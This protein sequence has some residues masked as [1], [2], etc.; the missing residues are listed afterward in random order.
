MSDSDSFI[1]EV[2]EEVRQDR[3]LRYWKR[4]GPWVIGAI[5]LVSPPRPP[6]TGSS[7]VRPSRRA[8]GAGSS[9]PPSPATWPPPPRSSSASTARPGSSRL[10]HAGALAR[11]GQTEAAIAEPT[12]ASRPMEAADPLYTDLAELASAR[13]AAPQMA[14]QA[15]IER[16]APLT[17]EGAPYRLLA[18]ELRAVLRLNAGRDRGRPCGSARDP[19]QPGPDRRARRPRPRAA[20]GERRHARPRDELSPAPSRP[21]SKAPMSRSLSRPLTACAMAA[22][23][24]AAGCSVFEDEERLEGER[25]PVRQA[26]P[27]PATGRV[28]QAPCPPPRPR[29]TGPRPA[30]TRRMWAGTCAR[31]AAR[32]RLAGRCGRRAEDDTAITAAPV[33]AGGRIFALDA[34]AGVAAFDAA[35]AARS[36]ASPSCP[37]ATRTASEGFGGGLAATPERL[38]VTTG[39]GEIL[40]LAAG[41]GDMIWRRRLPAPFR[42]GPAL[43]GGRL[44]AVTRDGTAY[45]IDAGDGGALAPARRRG[46]D[47]L[48]RRARARSSPDGPR[49]C[50]SRRASWWRSTSPPAG[51]AGAR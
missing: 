5:V 43:V 8:S 47:R 45:G 35:T 16:L 46:R 12:A 41:S 24:L 38:F 14:P 20:R 49:S 11:D 1:R 17:A 31:P 10:R 2:T 44:V 32:A 33:V 34:E 9:S 48:A 51:A 3:M 28:V 36:G 18:L 30:A 27:D 21:V 13:L 19:R 25:M 39:F 29:R 42:S 37:R 23:L 6:G 15:A 22:M 50:P 4:Y 7:S 26:L 40:A